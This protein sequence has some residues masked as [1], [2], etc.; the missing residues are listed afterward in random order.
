MA[1]RAR[2][3]ETLLARTGSS[4]S[5]EEQPQHV[6]DSQT[7][8]MHD[9]GAYARV[10]LAASLDVDPFVEAAVR[11]GDAGAACFISR[12]DGSCRPCPNAR[13]FE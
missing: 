4:W 11:L 3:G 2:F 8:R 5:L 1:F 13:L 9:A 7:G 12:I 10:L 6:S